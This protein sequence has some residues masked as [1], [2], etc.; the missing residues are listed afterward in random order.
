MQK[1]HMRTVLEV[2]IVDLYAAEANLVT[3]SPKVLK[4]AIE[5]IVQTARMKIQILL[6]IYERAATE[7]SIHPYGNKSLSGEYYP[8]LNLIN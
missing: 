2:S 1:S 8:P 6:N 7:S 3:E 4:D 5:A